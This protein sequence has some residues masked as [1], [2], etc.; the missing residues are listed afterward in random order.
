MCSNKIH[1]LKVIS[2][3]LL[4]DLRCH[5]RIPKKNIYQLIVNVL[6]FNSRQ[7][8]QYHNKAA[9]YIDVCTY[10]KKEIYIDVC[11][12]RKKEVYIY[13]YINFF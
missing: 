9:T 3:N 10:R 12:Y 13:I 1:V 11:T 4:H 6:T 2:M 7:K 8:V 5:P